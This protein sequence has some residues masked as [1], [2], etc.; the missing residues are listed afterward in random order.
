MDELSASELAGRAG[1]LPEDVERLVQ[2]GILV[3]GDGRQPFSTGDVRRVRLAGACAEAGLSLEGI[4]A[5]MAAGKLTLAFLDHPLFRWSGRAAETYRDLAAR[6]GLPM[7]LLR[8]GYE[9]TG[10]APPE[11]EEPVREDDL[12]LLPAIQAALAA[13]I[14]E[15]ATVRALRVFGDSL[16]R[17]AETQN[18]LFHSK[19]ELPLLRSGLSQRQ[20]IETASSR[21]GR[22]PP[23]RTAGSWPC[24][25]GSRSTPG[26]RTWSNTSRPRSRRPGSAAGPSSPRRSAF[27]TWWASR[28]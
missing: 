27:W 10:F 11:P 24:T 19:V 18:Q 23:T 6:L 20:M 2:L 22:W 4:G 25:G 15:D 7:A 26:S 5:A 8:R 16:R 1:V 17:I 28:G 9:A 13:G 12:E 3:P 21:A 14:D